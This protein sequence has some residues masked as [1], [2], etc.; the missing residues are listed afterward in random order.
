[1]PCGSGTH[2]PALLTITAY[3]PACRSRYLAPAATAPIV[4]TA[5]LSGRRRTAPHAAAG[6]STLVTAG[7]V[8]VWRD[9]SAPSIW[10]S[11]ADTGSGAML[12]FDL[13]VLCGT[14]RTLT[15]WRHLW[16]ATRFDTRPCIWRQ[17]FAA[18]TTAII[19]GLSRARSFIHSRTE[20]H[21]W[22]RGQRTR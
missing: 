7:R 17:P 20:P 4:A 14:A 12:D 3:S 9:V 10:N 11:V 5:L 21:K 19:L 6:L 2:R 16:L 22:S 13:V 15:S 18:P 8:L 1:M